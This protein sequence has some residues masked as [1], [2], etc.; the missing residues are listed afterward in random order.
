MFAAPRKAWRRIVVALFGV[1]SVLFIVLLATSPDLDSGLGLAL[2]IVLTPLWSISLFGTLLAFLSWFVQFRRGGTGSVAWMDA[3]G[4]HVK[5]GQSVAWPEVE[6]VFTRRA[7]SGELLL[8]VRPAEAAAFI[9]RAPSERQDGMRSNLE[10]YEAPLF[11]NVSV[12]WQGTADELASA[13]TRLTAG[14]LSL[15]AGG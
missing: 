15:A 5:G 14:R 8:C 13:I 7:E 6:S 11:I 4:V 3:E 12:F 2:V 10:T 1:C 9:A